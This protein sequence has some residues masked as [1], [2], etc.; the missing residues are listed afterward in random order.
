[1]DFNTYDFMTYEFGLLVYKAQISSIFTSPPPTFIASPPQKK[2]PKGF[3]SR[4]YLFTWILDKKEIKST[5]NVEEYD[6]LSYKDLVGYAWLL[7]Y[8][9]KTLVLT[10]CHWY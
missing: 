4:G 10:A 2:I 9:Y 1:M 5:N 6:A 8:F 7:F 3:V